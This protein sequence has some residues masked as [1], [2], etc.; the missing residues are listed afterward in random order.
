MSAQAT[1]NADKTAVL[2][3]TSISQFMAPIMV[4]A[5]S[6]ALPSISKQ[7]GTE[8]VISGWVANIYTLAA[9][10]FLIPFGRLAD[11]Y[12]RKKIFSLGIWLFTISSILCGFSNSVTLLIVLRALQG[13][14]SAMLFATSTAIVSSVFSPKERGRALGINTAAVYLGLSFGPFLGGLLT[15]YLTWRSIFFA[16]ALFGL[17]A[18]I[19]VI[20][21]L[22]G[23]WAEAKG[24]KFDYAGSVVFSLSI[25][26]VMYG[27]SVLPSLLGF[28]LVV[29]GI[30]GMLLFIR[31]AARSSSPILNIR[32]ISENRTFIF[33]CLSALGNYAATFAVSFLL[34]FYLQYNK[35]LSPQ[36]AGLVL[37]AQPVMQT[38]FSPIAGRLSDR[39]LPQKVATFGAILTCL[40]L[41]P[42]I[43]FTDAT[44]LWIIIACLAFLGLGFAFFSSPNTNAVM[45]SLDRKYLGTAA[46]TLATMRNAGMVFSMGIVMILFAV[47]IGD[48]QITPQNYPAFLVSQRISFIVFA[49]IC[50]ISIFLQLAARKTKP[51]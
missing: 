22:K 23:E 42:L 46:G 8:A 49:G 17:V 33:S 43:F 47:F 40:G 48:V 45:G 13:I 25:I 12:G 10:I 7:F 4:S 1:G 18:A 28:G 51:V 31:L 11:I 37:V 6:V 2:L 24:E 5:A 27:F 16:G 3:V 39:Y 14:G 50:F 44:A 36:I 20:W 41:L 9:T 30:L 34:S 15:G 21:K 38:I 35:G 29:L 26:L 19:L 32:V